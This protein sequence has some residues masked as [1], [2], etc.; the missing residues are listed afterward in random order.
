[1]SAVRSSRVAGVHLCASVPLDSSDEVFRIVGEELGQHVRRIPDGETG[2]RNM[3]I[4]WFAQMFWHVD[5]L[6]ERHPFYEE[7]SPRVIG[8][9][10]G[11]SAADIRYPELGYAKAALASYERFAHHKREGRIASEVRFQVS[12]PTPIA[13][14]SAAVAP[15]ELAALEPGYEAAQMAELERILA[16]IPHDELAIQ[17]DVCLEVWFLDGWIECPFS[18]VLD[19][20]VERLTRYSQAV[21]EDVELGFHLCYGDYKHEH[22]HQPADCSACVTIFNAAAEAIDRRIDWVHI[23]VPIEQDDDAYYAPLDR[24]RLAD[25]TELYLGLVHFRDGVEGAE[26]RIATARRHVG[27]FGVATECGM[28]RRPPERG[29]AEATL[30]ELLR[31]HAAVAEPARS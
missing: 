8:L 4:G 7:Y 10:D 12:L 3:W 6:E 31:I 19:G 5:D 29:G 14:I 30:R 24:L 1:M 27:A 21:P 26:R 17:W 22:L 25:G 13:T 23:P 18:P 20:I 16:G 15:P 2:D 11:R 28:G 9:A